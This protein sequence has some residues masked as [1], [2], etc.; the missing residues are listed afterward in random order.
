MQKTILAISG[1][2]GL[3]ELVS[4]G[5]GSL[6]VEALDGTHKRMPA[7]ATDRVTSLA[8]IAMYTD[9]DDMPLG[10]V[11]AALRDIESGKNTSLNWRKASTADLQEYFAKFVPNFDRDRVH[12]SDIKKLLQWYDIL[13]NAGITNFEEVLK[14]TNGDNID[15]RTEE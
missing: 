5:K 12:A 9:D 6:I 1:K 3:Y 15:D 2:P 8:D 4:R 14:P 13:V 10:Q 11:M 7:F